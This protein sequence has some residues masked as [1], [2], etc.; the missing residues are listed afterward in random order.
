MKFFVQQKIL[1]FFRN[2]YDIKDE[3]GN[4]AFHVKSNFFIP[5]KLTFY[6]N[7]EEVVLVVRKRYF[8]ILQRYDIVVDNKLVAFLKQKVSVFQKKFK[9]ISKTTEA[10]N[11]IQIQ[12]DVFGFSFQMAKDNNAVANISKKFLAIGDKYSIEINDEAN[13]NIYLAIAITIDDIVHKGR[14]KLSN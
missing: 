13:K 4:I 14:G 5:Y 1:T 3:D 11:D 10:L 12:G 2:E 9:I 6:N 8:R 7:K